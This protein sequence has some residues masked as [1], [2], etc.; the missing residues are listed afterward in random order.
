M[1]LSVSYVLCQVSTG[2]S[3]VFSLLAR[4]QVNQDHGVEGHAV[5]YCWLARSLTGFLLFGPVIIFTSRQSCLLCCNFGSLNGNITQL[6][7]SGW[8]FVCKKSA[9]KIVYHSHARVTTGGQDS[10]YNFYM[11]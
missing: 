5:F 3:I 9:L 1:Y 10:R 6:K 11:V 2:G 8:T 4:E 7:Q